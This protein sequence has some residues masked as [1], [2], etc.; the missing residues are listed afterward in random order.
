MSG[1]LDIWDLTV[2]RIVGQLCTNSCIGVRNRQGADKVCCGCK[3]RQPEN[4]AQRGHT[5]KGQDA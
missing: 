4:R 3:I 5:A 2:L 1:P